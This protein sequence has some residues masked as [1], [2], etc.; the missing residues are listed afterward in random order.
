VEKHN[1]S[2]TNRQKLAINTVSASVPVKE[3]S[4]KLLP[5]TNQTNLSKKKK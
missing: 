5:A 3:N 2:Q 1:R 4:K